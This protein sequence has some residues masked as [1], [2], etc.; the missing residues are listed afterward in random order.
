[1]LILLESLLSHNRQES[2]AD[3]AQQN[4]ELFTCETNAKIEI[5]KPYAPASPALVQWIK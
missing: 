3:E 2:S 5:E 4:E 1:L